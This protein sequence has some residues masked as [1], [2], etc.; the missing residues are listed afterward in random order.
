MPLTGR[1][2]FKRP[3]EGCNKAQIPKIIRWK[4]KMEP[5]QVLHVGIFGLGGGWSIS[6]QQWE[7]MDAYSFQKQS[8]SQRMAKKKI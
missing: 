3:L 4:F 7:K 8:Y 2:T 6:T 5:E 1:V